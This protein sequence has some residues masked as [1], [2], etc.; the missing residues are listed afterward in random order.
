MKSFAKFLLLSVIVFVLTFAAGCGAKT[1]CVYTNMTENEYGMLDN[2]YKMGGR[3]GG[4]SLPD[5]NTEN[6]DTSKFTHK[7][8]DPYAMNAMSQLVVYSDFSNSEEVTKFNNLSKAVR[9]KLYEIE[10]AISA[11]ATNSDIYKFNNVQAGE[12]LQ[13]NKI[14]YE[15]LSLSKSVYDLTDGYYNPALYYN[16]RAYGFGDD[17]IIP[18]ELP[19]DETIA[20]FTDLAMHFDE[21]ELTEDG[22]NY[23]VYKPEYTVDVD[24]ETLTL[25]LDLGGIGK[26]Y[27]VDCV[28]ELLDEYGFKFGYFSFGASSMLVKNNL[29]D[30]TFSLGLAGPRSPLRQLYLS[31]S[32]RNEKLSTSGDN[33]QY[34]S[35]DG[36]RYC[37]IIDPTT[38]KPVQ[39]GIMSVTVIGGGAAEADALTTAIMCMG[40]EKAIKFIEEKLTDRRVVFT[41]E[42]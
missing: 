26:G 34:Y 36:V 14:T 27:A 25:K 20:K 35:I 3:I 28:D 33:E 10:K 24:G 12:K 42:Q 41:L 38:G 15:V 17:D 5:N 2:D 30:G 6:T 16:V 37:H 40:K 31:T 7:F 4:L 18:T 39:T 23:F 13:I 21:I 22:D 29:G 8:D 19:K 32:I 1:Y 11:T 9:A